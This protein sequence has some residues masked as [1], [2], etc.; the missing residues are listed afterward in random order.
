M[1]L[2]YHAPDYRFASA[3]ASELAAH[4]SIPPVCASLTHQLCGF[5]L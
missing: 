3:Y 1:D 2:A 5:M 4:L